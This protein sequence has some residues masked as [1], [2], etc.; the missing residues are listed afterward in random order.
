L[1]WHEKQVQSSGSPY[2][3][4]TNAPEEWKRLEKSGSADLKF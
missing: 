3:K 4:L 2:T 1:K